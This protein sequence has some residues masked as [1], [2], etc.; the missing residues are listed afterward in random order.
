LP[1]DPRRLAHAYV[2]LALEGDGAKALDTVLAP[3][4]AGDYDLAILHDEVLGPAA[5]RIG[6]LW[7]T[8]LISVAEEH[9]ATRVTEEALAAARELVPPGTAGRGRKLVLACP[10]D[11]L[12]ETGLRMLRDALAVD[13]WDV[14][15]LGAST[16][17]RDLAA[18]VRKV[19]PAAVALS[20]ATPLAIPSL[21]LAVE[22]VRE[23][24]PELPV[25]VG[26]RAVARYPA[27][28]TAAGATAAYGGIGEARERLPLLLAA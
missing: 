28:A 1:A 8:G 17:A 6:E 10:A 5:A 24:A 16:P 26:G 19:G 11:E 20:C 2:E 15:L 13:G 27:V 14:S 18:H 22:A 12:H 25:V 4:R 9:I 7:Q 21:V 23:K 3:L